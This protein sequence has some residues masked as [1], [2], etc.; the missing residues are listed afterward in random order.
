MKHLL[1][2]LMIA[3]TLWPG[4]LQADQAATRNAIVS[5]FEGVS[6]IDAE[7]GNGKSQPWFSVELDTEQFARDVDKFIAA[8]R[9]NQTV[10]NGD[11]TKVCFFSVRGSLIPLQDLQAGSKILRQ[12][13]SY[14]M[15]FPVTL[16]LAN[17]GLNALT[18]KN[19]TMKF[20]A[21]GAHYT[22]ERRLNRIEQSTLSPTGGLAFKGKNFHIISSN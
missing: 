1:S 17:P 21:Q 11:H 2:Y 15:Y 19:I 4:L 7:V 3:L 16:N 13:Q 20:H 18:V 12:G 8:E 6:S 22:I 5:Y 10:I 9:C 14:I